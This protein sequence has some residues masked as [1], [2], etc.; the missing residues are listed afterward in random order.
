MPSKGVMTVPDGWREVRLGSAIVSS[1]ARRRPNEPEPK[2]LSC[3]KD[4]GVIPQNQLFGKR[5]ASADTS[6]YKLVQP[7]DFVYDPNLLWSGAIAQSSLAIVGLVS[8]VYEVFKAAEA[9][10]PGFLT[11]WLASPTRLS[12]YQRISVGTNVRRRRASIEDLGSLPLLLPPLP[13]QR[14]IAAVLDSIDEAIECTEEVIV[15]TERLRDSLLHDLLT[16]GLPGHHTAW[17]DVPGLGTIPDCWE[18]VRLGDVAEV[19]FSS[20]DKRT[21]DGELPVRLCNY[22]DVFY[23]RRILP[24]MAFMDATANPIECKRWALQRG[25]V[26]FT[27][28]SE[29]AD[30]IGIPAYVAADMPDVLCGYHLG[31]ARPAGTA[32][33]GAFLARAMGSQAT[34]REF[35]RVANGIT[36]FGL[37]LEATRALPLLLPPLPEQRAIAATL[38]S[39]DAA[40]ER[41]GAERA[42]LQSSKASAADALL[43]GRVRVPSDWELACAR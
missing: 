43:T 41:E 10:D 19:T 36:R 40:I 6:R 3:S 30:E 35:S 15:A 28:D 16:R 9:T 26:L 11:E 34:S 17:R 24:D 25:D 21:V 27:K 14:A 29:T 5:L 13:E 12:Q 22:T 38:D 42:A 20:V 2:I 23:N 31:I 7:G 4:Y 37:T 39:V 32:V 8:P 1:T 33:D 18:V